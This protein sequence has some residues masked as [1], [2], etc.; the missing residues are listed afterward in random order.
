MIV[1]ILLGGRLGYIVFYNLGY[2]LTYPADIFKLWH[3]GMSF[4]GG[5]LGL[6]LIAICFAKKHRI[7]IANLGDIIVF[8]APV[9]IFFGRLANFIN[10]E[11]YG[12]PTDVSWAVLFP[13]GGYLPRHPTQLYEAFLEGVVIFVVMIF[14]RKKLRVKPGWMFLL[15][16]FLYTSF[17]IFV[18]YFREPDPQIGY[19]GYFT[20]GQILSVLMLFLALALFYFFVHIRKNVEF[21]KY[22]A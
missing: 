3:G 9:G 16:M 19:I 8:V 14:M 13:M 6:I 17:R 10:G 1:G 18:E 11:L 7:N 15:F 5:V 4:H 12:K 20:M 2:Y 21:D 22:P